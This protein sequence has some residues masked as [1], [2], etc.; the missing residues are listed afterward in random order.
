[1]HGTTLGRRLRSKQKVV[2][3]LMEGEEGKKV[4]NRM[5]D[6]KEAAEKTL[7]DDGSSTKQIAELD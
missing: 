7:S 2:K 1:M 3:D 5:K 6:L 4:R